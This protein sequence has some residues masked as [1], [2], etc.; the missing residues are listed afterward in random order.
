ME[1]IIFCGI[2]ASGK[3]TFYS[4]R[5]L[6]THV[7]ISLDLLKTRNKED[8]LLDYCLIFGQ[9]FVVD[10]TNTTKKQR[11]HYIEKIKPYKFKITCYSF[12]TKA[13]DA[14]QRNHTRIAKEKVPVPGIYGTLKKLEPPLLEEGFDELYFVEIAA[15]EYIVTRSGEA[16]EPQTTTGK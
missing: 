1:S 15:E 14:I 12:L 7:R 3:T 2:Q 16:V 4:K 10:N 9:R 6:K 13:K 11:H 8:K 5:F